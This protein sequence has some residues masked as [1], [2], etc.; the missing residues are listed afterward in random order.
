VLCDPGFPRD[1]IRI[2]FAQKVNGAA[3]EVVWCKTWREISEVV[4]GERG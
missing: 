4:F 3:A 2:L 1:V